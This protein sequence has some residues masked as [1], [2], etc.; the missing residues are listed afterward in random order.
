MKL[1]LASTW[2]PARGSKRH[3]A[4]LVSGLLLLGAC[5]QESRDEAAPPIVETDTRV[6]EGAAAPSASAVASAHASASPR[7]EAEPDEPEAAEYETEEIPDL[8]DAPKTIAEQREGLLRRMRVL[9]ELDDEKLAAIEAALAKRKTTGQGN[10]EAT[11]HPMTR[12]E[13]V[14]KR[15]Q[16]GVRDEKKS[17]CGAP[18]MVPIF[19]PATETEEQA[20]VC[21]DRYEFPGIPCD[22]PLT[23]VTMSQGQE[24]CKAMGKRLCDAHEWEGGCAG[25]L[26]SPEEDYGFRGD[27]KNM[28]SYHNGRREIT[29][30][31]GPAKDHSKCATSSSKSKACTSSGWKQCGSN[32]FPTGAFP[33]CKSSF[34]VYDQHGNAAEHMAL[35]LKP[36]DLGSQGGLGVAEMKGSWFIFDKHEAHIDD[37][38]WRAPSWHDDEGRN[39]ANY[40]LGFRCCKDVD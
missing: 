37:C 28:R 25:A 4:L 20:R 7:A 36:A 16:A 19:D 39:H 9:H 23:W 10:P 40:H 32:T 35:P 29:W 8:D 15:R 3:S 24:I 38:R 2:R 22:Y 26:K 33:E 18:Y 30:A 21:I 31:Y 11:K 6:A 14:A 13:C 27:R 12:A 34:G 17:R 5:G 1:L